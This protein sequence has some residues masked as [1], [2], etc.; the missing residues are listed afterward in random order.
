MTLHPNVNSHPLRVQRN[1]GVQALDLS[2]RQL[3]LSELL[4]QLGALRGLP[5]PLAALAEARVTAIVDELARRGREE[6]RAA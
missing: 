1:P 2:L 3:S 5:E 4:R 6:V